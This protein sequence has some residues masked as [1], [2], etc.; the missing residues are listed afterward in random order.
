[1][2]S[3][4]TLSNQR[5]SIGVRKLLVM[6]L[7]LILL[8]GVG[9]GVKADVGDDVR[10]AL[11]GAD[12]VAGETLFKQ[13]CAR[14][15]SANLMNDL[16]GPALFGVLE[17]IPEGDWIYRWIKNSGAVIAT[18]DAYAVEIYDKW[19]KIQMDPNLIEDDQI[20]NILAWIDQWQP[21]VDT[22]GGDAG[23]N[24]TSIE[25]DETIS[26]MW[27]WIR[28]LIFL[29]VLLLGNIALQVARLRG[30]NFL[31]GVDMDKLN[32]RLFLGFLVL[33]LIGVFWSVGVFKDY[34][35]LTNS[36]SEHGAEIDSIFWITMVVVMAVFVL[37]NIVL[38]FFAFRYHHR[39]GYQ[40]KY[41]PEN[42]RLELL[43]TVV[44]AIVLT[45]LVIFGIR[46]WSRVMS[47]P[48][49]S[50]ELVKV[51]LNAQQFGWTIRYPG[52]DGEFGKIDVHLITGTNSL[53]ID[54]EEADKPADQKVSRD[55]FLSQELVIPK[56]RRVD[57]KLRSR[58]VLHSAYLPH[59]R[60]KMDC[61]PGMDT[62]FHFVPTLTTEEMRAIRGDSTFNYEL[63]CTEVCGKGH[64]SMQKIVRVLEPEEWDQWYKKTSGTS[65][66]SQVRPEP[67]LN[68]TGEVLT[69]D[70]DNDIK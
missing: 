50:E 34:F 20:N 70:A 37:T 13:N 41:Y 32:A 19:D 29:V 54:F 24:L 21:P 28:F 42:N 10:A 55:D 12:P 45:I 7:G 63:A 3:R 69:A 52:N 46:T 40:A 66:Y 18:G 59:F 9:A 48:D 16:T 39:E 6:M 38:F 51:E 33:G 43:W 60:V 1:M 49:P 17:R 62:R 36:A 23:A 65:L 44:P 22:G 4:K 64:F 67:T 35:L 31:A 14:C 57:L 8:S 26:G 27:N 68:V 11:D 2:I 25:E 30:V 53:G 58:D 47:E 56:G 5:H 61:V 15:H